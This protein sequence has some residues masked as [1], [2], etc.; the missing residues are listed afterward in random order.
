MKG[1]RVPSTQFAV[2]RKE[3]LLLTTEYCVLVLSRPHIFLG[4]KTSPACGP[5]GGSL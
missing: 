5:A 2:V 4:C 1:K 3:F